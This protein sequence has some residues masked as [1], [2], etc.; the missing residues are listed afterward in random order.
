MEREGNSVLPIPP[1][2]RGY[3][4]HLVGLYPT[5]VSKKKNQ[6]TPMQRK[7]ESSSILHCNFTK[8]EIIFSPLPKKH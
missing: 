1:E 5:H 2:Q 6:Y 4:S 7:N 3:I 8:I